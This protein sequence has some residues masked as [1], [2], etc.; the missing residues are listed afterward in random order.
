MKTLFWYLENLIWNAKCSYNFWLHGPYGLSKVIEK[1][2]FRYLIKYLRKYGATIGENCRFE[3]GMNIHRPLGEKPFENLNI[4]NNVYLGHNILLDLS[5]S[6][7]I[8]DGVMIG[9]RCQIW[10]HAGYYANKDANYSNY[11]ESSKEVVIFEGT[12]IYSNVVVSPGITIGKM[13]N[14]GANSLVNENTA[15]FGFYG[16]VPARRIK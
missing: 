13:A 7:T 3:R 11:Q 15:D 5:K 14:I 2:P 9:A 1:I 12:I 8:N 6:I 10:T 4:G 16:G